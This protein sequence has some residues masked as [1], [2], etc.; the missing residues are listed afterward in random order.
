[1]RIKDLIQR[2]SRFDPEMVLIVSSDAEGD[3]VAPLGGLDEALYIMEADHFGSLWYPETE[4][5][6]PPSHAVPALVLYPL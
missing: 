5:E 4:E 6:T 1:M 3:S 2:L